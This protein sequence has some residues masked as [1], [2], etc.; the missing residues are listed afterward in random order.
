MHTW[1]AEILKNLKN[2]SII[3]SSHETKLLPKFCDTLVEMNKFGKIVEIGGVDKLKADRVLDRISNL[4]FVDPEEK[5]DEPDLIPQDENHQLESD[6]LDS[7]RENDLD[8][9]NLLEDNSQEESQ[10]LTKQVD[11]KV[12]LFYFKSIGWVTSF[13]ILVSLLLMQASRVVTDYYL[14]Y[15]TD[16]SNSS[17]SS[18]T[19]MTDHFRVTAAGISLAKIFEKPSLGIKSESGPNSGDFSTRSS[20]NNQTVNNFIQIY[21]GLGCL[22]IILTLFRAFIF[23]YGGIAACQIIFNQFL[24]QIILKSNLKFFDHVNSSKLLTR[25]TTDTMI[26]DDNL[27]FILNILLAN[28]ATTIGTIILSVYVF[29]PVLIVILVLSPYYRGGRR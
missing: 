5:A 19:I 23:A 15:S 17:V 26:V 4:S 10:D 3:C 24:D 11:L 25:L 28:L 18:G 2:I 14:A 20:P 8:T 21:T 13:L 6:S 29:P 1:I 16:A 12:I 27:P 7:N 22:N 9:S